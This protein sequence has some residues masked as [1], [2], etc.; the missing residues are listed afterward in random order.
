MSV[1]SQTC[2]WRPL[3]AKTQAARMSPLPNNT[4]GTPPMMT[5][6]AT[7]TLTDEERA[8]LDALVEGWFRQAL[9]VIQAAQR[10]GIEPLSAGL[11]GPDAFRPLP[12]LLSR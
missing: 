12:Q 6:T 1:I 11:P 10:T 7:S 4:E 3:S 9:H 2:E 5:Q 8:T